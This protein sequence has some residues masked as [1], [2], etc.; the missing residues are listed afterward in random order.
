[1]LGQSNLNASS[2]LFL[3]LLALSFSLS[4]SNV[5]DEHKTNQA[6]PVSTLVVTSVV[7]VLLLLQSL[8]FRALSNLGELNLVIFFIV[9]GLSF[10]LS[11]TNVTDSEHENKGFPTVVLVAN[12]AVLL[13]VGYQTVMNL[14][15]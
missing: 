12:S 5:V 7:M 8:G 2:C 10:V 3:I 11:L 15:K 14:M 13:M 4:V 9:L 6:L 1:M